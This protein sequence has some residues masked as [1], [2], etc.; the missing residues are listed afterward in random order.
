MHCPGFCCT[1]CSPFPMQ[2]KSTG[3]LSFATTAMGLA[4]CV[5]RIFTSIQEGAGLSMVRG[6][7]LGDAHVYMYVRH[8]VLCAVTQGGM[9][10]CLV[11]DLSSTSQSSSRSCCIARILRSR[12]SSAPRSRNESQHSFLPVVRCQLEAM[13]CCR[14]AALT[15]PCLP[16]CLQSQCSRLSLSA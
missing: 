15:Y 11:Q 6:F 2:A 14:H 16:M 1:K 4:G 8:N 3:Q 7:V 13:T 5:A 12:P 10:L 9:D